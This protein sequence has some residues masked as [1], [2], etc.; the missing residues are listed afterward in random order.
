MEVTDFKNH[1]F[2]GQ[3]IIPELLELLLL[4]KKYESTRVKKKI[5]W[6]SRLRTDDLV[7]HFFSSHI[8]G[9]PLPLGC[10]PV[11]LSGYMFITKAVTR[12]M[13]IAFDW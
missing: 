3:D 5:G 1:V 11:T 9:I 8:V 2:L 7:S 4:P 6:S 12:N 13:K 10:A